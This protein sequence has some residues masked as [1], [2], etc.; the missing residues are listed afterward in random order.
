MKTGTISL[1]DNLIMAYP[2]DVGMKAVSI[3]NDAE[4]IKKYKGEL[5]KGSLDLTRQTL[6]VTRDIAS[7]Y[8]SMDAV[9]KVK[10]KSYLETVMQPIFPQ[11]SIIQ[12]RNNFILTNHKHAFK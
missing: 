11:A 1:V 7:E 5:D 10:A 4:Q 9:Q 6:K 8:Q 12:T 3:F 2:T